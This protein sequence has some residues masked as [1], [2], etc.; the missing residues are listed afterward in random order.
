LR[1]GDLNGAAADLK[2]AV[3]SEPEQ[4]WHRYYRGACAIRAGDP[5]LA[6]SSFDVCV[7]LAPRE[8][9]C[10]YNR[11]LA[12]EAAGDTARALA[13]YDRALTLAPGSAEALLNRGLLRYRCKDYLG[14]V[15]D[16]RSARSAGIDPVLAELNLAVVCLEAGERAAA[17]EHVARLL[18]LQPDN[19]DGLSLRERLADPVRLEETL[20]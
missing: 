14:A 3:E 12:A 10:Y 20:R 9:R 16:L 1:A 18:L 17:R 8:W 15:T 11:A 13:D 4:F 2:T 7:A 5:A 6:A 19:A